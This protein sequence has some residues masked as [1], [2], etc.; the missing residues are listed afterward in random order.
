MEDNSNSEDDKENTPRPFLIQTIVLMMPFLKMLILQLSLTL[1]IRITKKNL[2][3]LETKKAKTKKKLV[4]LETEEIH[5]KYIIEM[6]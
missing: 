1:T 2:A 4:N 3:K 5:T 6:F